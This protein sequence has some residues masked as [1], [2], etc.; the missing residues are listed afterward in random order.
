MRF[1]VEMK[2]SQKNPCAV[3][4]AKMC[5]DSWNSVHV[6]LLTLLL[7]TIGRVQTTKGVTEDS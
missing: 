4:W 3:R 2:K 7:V 1:P 5:N 6:L